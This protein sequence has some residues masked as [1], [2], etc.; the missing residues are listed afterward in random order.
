M[1][2]L[3]ALILLSAVHATA[4]EIY[5]FSV[6]PA[7]GTFQG[8]PGS[9]VGWGYSIENESTS[10]WLVTTA[11]NSG[12]FQNGSPT[13][14]FDFPAVAPG[15]TVTVPFNELGATGLEELTWDTSAPAGF[16]N[17]GTF[18][19]SAQWWDGDPLGIGSFRFAAS[20]SAIPYTATV[21]AAGVPEPATITP[22]ALPLIA[23]GLIGTRRSRKQISTY[24]L[25]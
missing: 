8:A 12:L 2:T 19:L 15:A 13:L 24:S 4:A 3:F 22:I 5:D 14:L 1:K 11:M 16:S 25:G 21:V 10:F 17:T 20:D 9:T 6:L 18:T 23:L 7:G